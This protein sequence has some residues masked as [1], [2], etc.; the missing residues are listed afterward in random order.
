MLETV[1]DRACREIVAIL[2]STPNPTSR[3]VAR[4]KL[5]VAK[6][7]ALPRIPSNS[8][9]LRYV[10][11][12]E[13]LRKLL[14]RKPVRSISGVIVVAVMTKPYPCPQSAPCLYCPGGPRYGTP[15][16]YT[17]REPAALRAIQYDYDPYKQVK[18]RME[19]LEKVGHRVDKVELII[20]GGTF[21]ALPRGYTEWFVK[22]CLDA[23]N[24][25]DSSSL[26]EAKKL[27][28][29]ASTKVSGITVETRPDWCREEHVDLMLNLGVTR[30]EIGVQTIYDHVY[31]MVRR[32]HRVS[33]VV[34]ATRIAKDAGLKV[35]YHMMPGLPGSDRGMDVEMF[36]EVFRNPDF[37]PDALKIYPCLVVKGSDLYDLWVKGLYKPYGCGELIDLL[38]EA[39]SYVPPYIRIQRIQRDI[40]APLI[41]AGCRFG[42]LREYVE[43]EMERRGKPCKCIRCREVGHKLSRKG[44][45]PGIEDIV[46]SRIDYEASG[47]LELFLSFEDKARDVLIGYLRLR[48][49]SEYA[50]REELRGAAI[51]RELHVYGPMLPVGLKPREEW[52]HR[53]LGRRLLF[54]AE[55]IAREE[56]DLKKIAV[57]S[58]LGVKKYYRRLGYYYDGPYMSKKLK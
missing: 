11:G 48:I 58:G 44:V 1:F 56:Y 34:E 32:G 28:E 50:H 26:E 36:R 18:A 14:T 16:S 30:V 27:A 19:Q 29:D 57:I 10:S 37:R 6:K 4:V 9:L 41:E 35:T 12:Y 25:R 38:A 42:N 23:F 51:V 22:R 17:G 15:Q 47:G 7:Y 24:G 13:D 21:T 5:D 43:A 3:D 52:Q 45:K 55:R 2:A 46:L 8:E 54:E 33:D 39:L 31:S 49:P 53:S 20:L 40:P